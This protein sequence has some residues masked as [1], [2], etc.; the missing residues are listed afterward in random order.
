MMAIVE[1]AREWRVAQLSTGITLYC[2]SA[3]LDQEEEEEEEEDRG[4]EG[5][6]SVAYHQLDSLS[7]AKSYRDEQQQAL[8]GLV[9]LST[10]N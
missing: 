1:G 8:M 3:F 4:Q 10:H 5:K 9:R 2:R 7:R 6:K